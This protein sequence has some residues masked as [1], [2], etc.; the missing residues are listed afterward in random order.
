VLGHDLGDLVQRVSPVTMKT[1]GRHH[2]FNATVSGSTA[3][4][5]LRG[6]RSVPGD[7]RRAE[8]VAEPGDEDLVFAHQPTSDCERR[9]RDQTVIGRKRHEA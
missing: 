2:V 6:W 7:G 9:R 5:L 3:T 4:R 1:G 8:P